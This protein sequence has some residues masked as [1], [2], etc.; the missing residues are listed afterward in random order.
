MESYTSQETINRASEAAT[1]YF[2]ACSECREAAEGEGAR[3]AVTAIRR[4]A[5]HRLVKA[6]KS[7]TDP[8]SARRMAEFIARESLGA[9]AWPRL[10]ETPKPWAK[11]TETP[12]TWAVIERRDWCGEYR[13]RMET[14]AANSELPPEQAGDRVTAM[15]T[16]RGA[17]K[18]S[19]SC[20]Y[21][22]TARGGY[23]TFLT[24]TLTAEA[25][26]KLARRVVRPAYPM[27]E[28]GYL[29]PAITPARA[30]PGPFCPDF[31]G[32]DQI[33]T[34]NQKA[35][36]AAEY[37]ALH[38]ET[39]RPFTPL[40]EAW[41][42]SVQKEA[43]RFFEAAGKMYQRGW[44]YQND[45]GETVRVPGSRALYC[46]M[47]EDEDKTGARFTRLKWWREPL[48]YL[49]VAENPDRI[50]EETGEVL[51]ENPHLHVLMRWRVDYR[52]FQAWAKRL[53]RLWGQGMA[54][55][56]KL[57][58]P[59]KA[60]GYVAKAAGY[61]SKSQGKTD[62]GEIRGNRY[63]ISSRARAPGWI[64]C[65]RHQV[66]MMGWLLAE[67]HEAWNRKH[68]PKIQQR[69]QLKRQLDKATT[70]AHRQKIGKI[71]EGVRAKL[72]PLP[73]ISKYGAIFKTAEQKQRFII[74]AK[75]QGWTEK[76]QCSQW[77]HQW[78]REQLR[79]RNGSRLMAGGHDW[80]AWF[81][82]ADAGAV[83]CNDDEQG[84]MIA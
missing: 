38:P 32:T 3:Q 34:D 24:L 46:V 11:H 56:E 8:E 14:R 42:W 37:S 26:E 57:K 55:L 9:P 82:L 77:L 39:G 83:A 81:A 30:K 78:R 25:R 41:A 49:W 80:A 62:Q 23:S 67:A 31:S 35:E 84:L 48:D 18:I 45:K 40:R 63:G 61:L 19:E 29:K 33:A 73:K 36:I 79:R 51:G 74:W 65:E 20:Y 7:P 66:G 50:D 44:Q 5:A 58:D 15:L 6:A 47:G 43:S 17:R 2:C 21:V 52:H 1:R 10:I 70:P 69:E 53:E 16:D 60:G 4:A 64:E 76:P 28:T 22:A 13:I 54:H 59:A 71:L 12:G 72:E 68:G 27:T 75:K